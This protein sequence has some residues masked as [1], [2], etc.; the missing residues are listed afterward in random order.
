VPWRGVGK[1]RARR[2]GVDVEGVAQGKHPEPQ[3]EPQMEM[4]QQV[5]G[6]VEAWEMDDD[7]Q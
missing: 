7:K 5:K 2:R 4:E 3:Y 1:G 6:D